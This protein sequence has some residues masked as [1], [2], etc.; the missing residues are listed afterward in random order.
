V[1]SLALFLATA[2]LALAQ[3]VDPATAHKMAEILAGLVPSYH[4]RQGIS[5]P[6]YIIIANRYAVDNRR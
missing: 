3:V 5:L 4:N 6:V 2:G 1:S